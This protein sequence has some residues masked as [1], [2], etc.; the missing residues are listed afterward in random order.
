MDRSEGRSASYT[1]LGRLRR[2]RQGPKRGDTV[3]EVRLEVTT[4]G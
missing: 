4:A 1:P 2:Y 3:E